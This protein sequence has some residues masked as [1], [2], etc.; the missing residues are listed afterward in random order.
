MQIHRRLDMSKNG[1][2]SWFGIK[3]IALGT[4]GALGALIA[5]QVTAQS[6]VP[7]VSYTYIGPPPKDLK[8]VESALNTILRRRVQAEVR[9]NPLDWGEFD[10]K[11]KLSFAAN[12]KCDIIFTA[13][14]INNYYQNVAQNNLL[15]LDDLLSKYAP[16]T[17]KSMSADTWNATRVDGKIYGVI[18]QQPQVRRY[19][20]RVR[21]DFA[22]KYKLDL[23]KINKYEDLEPFLAALKKGEPDVTP[24]AGNDQG[25]S[26]LF[27]AEYH[28]FDPILEDIG[29]A[30]RVSDKNLKMLSIYESAE[31]KS[32]VD[33][34]RKWYQ[35]GYFPTDIVAASDTL[36]NW[37]AGKYAAVP[38]VINPDTAFASAGQLGFAFV[39]K[40]FAPP[41]KSTNGVIATMN[42]I[43]RTSA[44]PVAAMKVL[45]QLST[46]P[47][48][49]NTLA[50]GVEGKHWVW[51]DR[52]RKVIGYPSGVTA[53]TS[54]YNPATDWMF[55]NIFN[56]YYNDKGLVGSI[57]QM[58]R[59]NDEAIPSPALGFAMDTEPVKSQ[60]ARVQAV[61]KELGVPL[62]AGVV[63]PASAVPA[64]ISALK[65]AGMDQIVAEAQKQIDAWKAKK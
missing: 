35:A 21:A 56:G 65:N 26:R 47:Q 10:Q 12:E 20:I 7:V 14:W 45:E 17:L 33:L 4:L 59:A 41:V 62:M 11:V 15:P 30:V 34:T 48:V 3:A 40:P 19:G 55:G 16:K 25:N 46:N 36:T 32:S 63:D 52:A 39:T 61:V 49:Y 23:S 22:S 8:V 64:Y 54:P 37:K 2:R 1:Q 5:T 29:L 50:K 38:S 51:V 18:N 57:E 53:N 28:G 27:H 13:P 60:V 58:K 31:F 24:L 6:N 44:N 9:L 43:C 42:G